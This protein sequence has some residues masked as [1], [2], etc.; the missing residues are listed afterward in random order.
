MLSDLENHPIL[1]FCA[2]HSVVL[3]YNVKI[4]PCFFSKKGEEK[5]FPLYITLFV[6][7]LMGPF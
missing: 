3:L 1:W 6:C 2:F 7:L 4:I 5:Q